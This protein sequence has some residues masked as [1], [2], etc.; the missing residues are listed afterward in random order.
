MQNQRNT[1]EQSK[2]SNTLIVAIVD[3]RRPMVEHNQYRSLDLISSLSAHPLFTALLK[4]T[5]K[6]L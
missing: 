3:S 5:E 6:Y 1:V 4:S 2:K